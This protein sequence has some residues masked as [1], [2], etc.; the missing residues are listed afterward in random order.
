MNNICIEEKTQ[1][2][3]LMKNLMEFYKENSNLDKLRRIVKGETK[4]SLRIVDWFV[5]NY[6]KKYYIVYNVPTELSKCGSYF[7]VNDKTSD[8]TEAYIRFKVYND[9]KLKLRA[10]SKR[11]FDP[12]NRW[13]RITIPCEDVS[14]GPDGNMITT[15]GQLNFFKWAINNNILDY[16]QEN[17][18]AI[19]LDMNQRNTMSKKKNLIPFQSSTTGCGGTGGETG[20]T[21]ISNDGKTRKKREELSISACKTVK[22]EKVEIV[23]KFT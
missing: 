2:S 5:T 7:I 21:I 16:I 9:Y 19:E 8:S 20:T 6:S 23:I 17:Y 3:L 10:Y 12:F 4:L 1:N 13:D 15:I 22:K 18:T 11:N 14:C